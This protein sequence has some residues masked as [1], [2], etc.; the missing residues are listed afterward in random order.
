[1][2]NLKRAGVSYQAL[3][4]RPAL[5]DLGILRRRD[6]ENTFGQHFI[7]ALQVAARS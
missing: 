5:I 4:G 6:S 2:R 1:V 7:S 3:R